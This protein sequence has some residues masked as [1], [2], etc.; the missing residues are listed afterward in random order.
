M[1]WVY[2]SIPNIL[3]MFIQCRLDILVIASLSI[4]PWETVPKLTNDCPCPSFPWSTPFHGLYKGRATTFWHA[5]E[6]L[7]IPMLKLE[8]NGDKYIAIAVRIH[9]LVRIFNFFCNSINFISQ[10]LIFQFIILR[11]KYL[12]LLTF[13]FISWFI[14]LC[15]NSLIHIFINMICILVIFI[16]E[17]N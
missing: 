15:S 17:L 4:K 6:V 10:T 14:Q 3:A 8:R 13:I 11:F 12:L 9:R 16:V 2:L 1:Y 5:P 7:N